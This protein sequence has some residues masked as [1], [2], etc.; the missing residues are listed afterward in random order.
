MTW[1]TKERNN[2]LEQQKV[3]EILET[4]NRRKKEKENY[5]KNVVLDFWDNLLKANKKLLPEV[6]ARLTS[7]RS[8][9]GLEREI[10]CVEYEN[11]IL[12][13]EPTGGG[14]RISYSHEKEGL[15]IGKKQITKKHI[16][17]ILRNICTGKYF[18]AG[19]A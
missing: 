7:E 6:G 13:F 19:L 16:D 1:Q 10:A 5:G 14:Q 15:C 4:E 2:R 8:L 11:E 3:Q 18:Y 12:I 9:Q 17:H